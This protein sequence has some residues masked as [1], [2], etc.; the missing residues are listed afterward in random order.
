MRVAVWEVGILVGGAQAW[1]YRFLVPVDSISY[2]DMSDGVLRGG[3]WHRLINGVWSPLY[4]FLIGL[5]RRV[6]PLS[7]ANEIAGAH[8]LNIG[9]FFFA[10][11]FFCFFLPS[12][13]R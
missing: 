2:L 5:A 7:A 6:I 9:F 12:A 11:S 10:L 3:D 13:I 1:V 4:P 8:V